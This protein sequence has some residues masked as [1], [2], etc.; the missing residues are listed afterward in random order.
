MQPSRETQIIRRTNMT[1]QR[2]QYI[3]QMI[4]VFSVS[5]TGLFQ[6]KKSYFYSLNIFLI[7]FFSVKQ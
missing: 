4:L 3:K 1:E 7:R 2:K 6:T 5:R